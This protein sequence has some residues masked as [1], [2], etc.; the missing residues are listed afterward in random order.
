MN[1]IK[2]YDENCFENLF[3]FYLVVNDCLCYKLLEVGMGRIGEKLV[4][5]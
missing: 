1:V 5:V 4:M 2:I 3:V